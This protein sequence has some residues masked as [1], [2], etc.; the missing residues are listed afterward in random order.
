M[1]VSHENDDIT[2]RRKGTHVSLESRLSLTRRRSLTVEPNASAF[3]F[4]AGS[5]Y[6]T[7]TEALNLI[8][9][10]NAYEVDA[11]LNEVHYITRS[12]QL[13][14]SYVLK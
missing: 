6:H 3:E 14:Q 11:R 1:L 12:T 7:T 8:D 4:K 5:A 10:R 9:E 13:R 2:T